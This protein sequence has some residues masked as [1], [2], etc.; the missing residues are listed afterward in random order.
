MSPNRYDAIV[1]GAG[2]AGLQA[3]HKLQSL[4]LTVKVVE[5]LPDVGGTWLT[6]NYPGAMSDTESYMYRFFWDKEDLYT[7]PWP[8]RYLTQPEILAYI[9][10]VVAKH[11]MRPHIQFN[12]EVTGAS[13]DDSAKEWRVNTSTGEHFRG[14]Y[15]FPC[16]G[17]LSKPVFPD[18]PGIDGF[19]GALTHSSQWD[20]E[21]DLSGK[22]VGIIGC[23]ATGIQIITAIAP[24]VASLISFQRTPQ[25]SVPAGNAPIS[26]Q[27]RAWINIH[28]DEL[29]NQIWESMAGFGFI[30]NPRPTMSVSAEEREYIFEMLW[31][32]GS[33][34]HFMMGGFGDFVIDPVAN[35]EVCKFIRKKISQIVKD[36][37][38]ARNLMPTEFYARRPVCDS[39][40][41]DACN[42]DNVQIVN[43]RDTPIVAITASGVRM[44]DGKEYELDALIIAT[45]FDAFD[46]GFSSFPIR[47][48]DGKLLMDCWRE[49]P[50]TY[51]GIACADFPNMFMLTGPLSPFGNIPAIIHGTSWP[52][53]ELINKNEQRE[54][55]HV[56]EATHEAQSE[57]VELCDKCSEGNLIQKTKSWLNGGNVKG[58]PGATRLYLGG[59]KGY[60]AFVS[61]M[62]EN[63]Y[64]GFRFM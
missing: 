57:W 5:R 17:I 37:E 46:G 52:I 13:W 23:G 36:P 6:N 25:Y 38:K 19:Q 58:E 39:G 63:D 20:P 4:N 56:V 18:I 43:C 27:Q 15:F 35:E 1:V 54:D 14:R 60:K 22:R 48:R 11:G 49:R 45:G 61:G 29:I 16:L 8:N 30:E 10:H 64:R 12:T 51:L 9:R 3:L 26:S 44:S 28:Y 40:Y 33:G 53:F 21:L 34:M 24:Q 7:Y 50:K 42:R 59:F 2:M 31:Q 62:I 32:Y 55:N 47:G 41:Y